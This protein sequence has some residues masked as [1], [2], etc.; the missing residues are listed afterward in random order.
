MNIRKLLALFLSLALLLPVLALAQDAPAGTIRV[1]LSEEPSASD[2]FAQ[3][4]K[5]WEAATGNK[6]E[7]LIIPYDDQLTKFP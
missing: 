1:L 3:T 7:L 4:L 2:A 6:A 5:A